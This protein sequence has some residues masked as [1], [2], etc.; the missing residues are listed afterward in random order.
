MTASRTSLKKFLTSDIFSGLRYSYKT[1]NLDL[2]HLAGTFEF[3]CNLR[4]LYTME[5]P[6]IRQPY[7]SNLYKTFYLQVVRTKLNLFPPILI[8]VLA[9]AAIL[10]RSTST[11]FI[12]QGVWISDI[13]DTFHFSCLF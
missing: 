1:H 8:E 9:N 10:P 11:N 12:R 6:D 7:L 4:R 3:R 2:S 13:L 5:S